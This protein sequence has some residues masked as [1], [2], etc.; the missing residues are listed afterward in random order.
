MCIRTTVPSEDSGVGF[1]DA[2]PCPSASL[3]VETVAIE[4]NDL[5]SLDHP[6]M[7]TVPVCVH[8]DPD[9]STRRKNRSKSN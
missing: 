6:F 1:T 9:N 7:C 2:L 3:I 5:I 4:G 8:P